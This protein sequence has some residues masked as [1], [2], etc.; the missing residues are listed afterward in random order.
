M[1]LYQNFGFSILLFLLVSIH[2]ANNMKMGIAQ[3]FLVLIHLHLAC[4]HIVFLLFLCWYFLE[5]LCNQF[6][7]NP[8][9]PLNTT[10][11]DFCNIHK[12]YTKYRLF[13]FHFLVLIYFL[14]VLDMSYFCLLFHNFCWLHHFLLLVLEI[15]FLFYLPS[16]MVLVIF[17]LFLMMHMINIIV[18]PLLWMLYKY[19]SFLRIDFLLFHLQVQFHLVLKFLCL[20]PQRIL[21]LY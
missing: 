18:F 13:C 7:A 14:K 9:V 12:L 5:C 17:L 8:V 4:F 16:L 15:T 3:I 10:Y 19:W 21:L 6:L 1:N 11:F 20:Y 2:I